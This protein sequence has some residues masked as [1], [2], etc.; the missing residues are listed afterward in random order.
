[1]EVTELYLTESD[2][3]L[4]QIPSYAT[5]L[6]GSKSYRHKDDIDR[7]KVEKIILRRDDTGEEHE[8][9][10]VVREPY[11]ITDVVKKLLE[12]IDEKNQK[13][14]H[15]STDT[16]D[17]IVNDVET[18]M[19]ANKFEDLMR[20]ILRQN[21]EKA[22][23]DSPFREIHLL[24]NQAG[25][26]VAIPLRAN[27]FVAEVIKFGRIFREFYGDAIAKMSL[28]DLLCEVARHVRRKFVGV[29]YRIGAESQPE[30]VFGSVAVGYGKNQKLE[31]RDISTEDVAGSMQIEDDD[32]G[33]CGLAEYAEER[34]GSIFAC[35]PLMFP[36]RVKD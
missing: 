36:V 6:L 28:A 29:N 3:R 7:I 4:L 30:F 35:V 14:L 17:L 5:E 33:D 24:T 12:S 15:Y 34:A 1:M 16:T 11:T 19:R 25:E 22:V 18:K 9:E 27:L 31:V 21:G 13:C 32:E 8:L 2:A 20:T 26:Q 10:A 23:R